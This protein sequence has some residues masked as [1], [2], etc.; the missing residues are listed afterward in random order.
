MDEVVALGGYD[1][2]AVA[3]EIQQAVLTVGPTFLHDGCHG[4]EGDAVGQE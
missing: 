4:R 2:L 1:E 3:R